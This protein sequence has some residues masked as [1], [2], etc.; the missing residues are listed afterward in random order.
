M[1]IPWLCIW[2]PGVFVLG[3][4]VGSF[5]NVVVARIPTERSLFWPSSHCLSCFQPIRWFHNLPIFGYIWLKGRCANCHKSYSSRYMWVEIA[6][7]LIFSG[8]FALEFLCDIRGVGWFKLFPY[9]MQLGLVP[10]QGWVVFLV[11]SVLA[12]HLLAASLCDI[13]FLEIPLPITITGTLFGLALSPLTAWPFPISPNTVPRIATWEDLI[14]RAQIPAGIMP[15]PFWLPVPGNFSPGS[16]QLGLVDGILGMI[17]GALICRIVRWV[18]SFG[19]GMEG[20][21]VGDSDLMM[22]AGAFLGWQVVLVGFFLSVFPGILVGLA[23]I[24]FKGTQT[25]PFGPSLAL[26]CVLSLYSWPWIGPLVKNLFFEPVLMGIL[27]ISS[28]LILGASGIIFR[29]LG[30]PPTDPSSSEGP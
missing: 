9:E 28:I 15:W 26:G 11:F 16:W 21:G 25:L 2:L 22:M 29:I 14:R 6:T 13:E 20:M 1:E 24:L 19:R 17:V 4:S 12:A 5:L 8:I 23:Q 3:A 18:Y 7:G 10:W 30:G 27:G